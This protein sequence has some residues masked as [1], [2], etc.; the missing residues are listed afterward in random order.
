MSRSLE[1]SGGNKNEFNTVVKGLQSEIFVPIYSTRLVG[2]PVR[3][4][5]ARYDKLRLLQQQ[6]YIQI[7]QESFNLAGDFT[8]RKFD[9]KCPSDKLMVS[10]GG[11]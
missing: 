7:D 6:V 8:W 3:E 1:E 9:D 10:H 11:K 2:T 4:R 5:I